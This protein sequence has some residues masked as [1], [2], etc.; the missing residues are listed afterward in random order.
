VL[1]AIAAPPKYRELIGGPLAALFPIGGDPLAFSSDP[2]TVGVDRSSLIS[3]IR[4]RGRACSW[5]RKTVN[6]AYADGFVG[7]TLEICVGPVSPPE[8]LRR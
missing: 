7:V 2:L 1:D 6:L 4:L 3:R 5:K 8:S